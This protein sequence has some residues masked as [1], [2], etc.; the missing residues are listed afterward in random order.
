MRMI[1]TDEQIADLTKLWAQGLTAKA[2]SLRLKGHSRM[3]VIGKAH[4]LELAS[5]GR[6]PRKAQ[7]QPKPKPK[8]KP[9]PEPKPGPLFRRWLGERRLPPPAAIVLRPSGEPEPR[10]LT[11][12]QLGFETCRWPHGDRP[13]FR[14][15]G[16]QSEPQRPYCAWHGQRAHTQ[17]RRAG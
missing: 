5:R 17:A 14:Y 4:R 3:S 12:M 13:P 9:K 10:G 15:C 2:I 8:P 1:W 16:H 7:P 6:E 11:I